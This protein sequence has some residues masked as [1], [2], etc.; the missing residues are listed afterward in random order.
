[1]SSKRRKKAQAP[2]P[3]K[4]APAGDSQAWPEPFK[5]HPRLFLLLL[6]GWAAWMAAMLMLYFKVAYPNHLFS[7][8]ACAG[9]APIHCIA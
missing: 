1:M 8:G 9:P 7:V 3:A 4:A 5:E 6:L 2:E